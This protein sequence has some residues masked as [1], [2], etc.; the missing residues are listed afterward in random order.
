MDLVH[1]HSAGAL[2]GHGEL[3]GDVHVLHG[4]RAVAVRGDGCRAA[5]VPIRQA[6][7]AFSGADCDCGFVAD[8]DFIHLYRAAARILHGQAAGNIH[9]L[10]GDAAVAAGGDGG[11]AVDVRIRQAQ[12]ALS[13]TYI[14]A[15][16]DGHIVH[17]HLT[18][19]LAGIVSCE[20][21][22][23]GNDSRTGEVRIGNG[24]VSCAIGR[25]RGI[26]IGI[27]TQVI[28]CNGAVPIGLQVDSARN[29]RVVDRD[30]ATTLTDRIQATVN[31]PIHQIQT[32][33]SGGNGNSAIHHEITETLFAV[34][35][36]H[37]H[38][39]VFPNV[40]IQNTV[41]GNRDI[42]QRGITLEDVQIDFS[43]FGSL[44]GIERDIGL[45]QRL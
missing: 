34:V 45:G 5:D 18:A 28:D 9:L 29:L 15:A 4:D 39:A 37:E 41:L 40:H 21:L 26:S 13:G 24:N 8:S 19:S 16:I 32:A 12:I 14:P 43:V 20:I 10:H 2:I 27:R 22:V 25:E 7:I 6:Q 1:I 11:C 44:R 35:R 3:S 30:T 36:A 33:L 42:F 38:I 23:V 31:G 17:F